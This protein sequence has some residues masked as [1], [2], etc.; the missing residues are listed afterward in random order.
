MFSNLPHLELLDLNGNMLTNFDKI[1]TYL[2]PSLPNLTRLSLYGNLFTVIV[3]GQNF[4]QYMQKNGSKIKLT[5]FYNPFE[6]GCQNLQLFQLLCSNATRIHQHIFELYYCRKQNEMHVIDEHVY[7][8]LRGQQ[9]TCNFLQ[10]LPII[11]PSAA[12]VFCILL[13]RT[14]YKKRWRF[15]L[16]LYKLRHG[17][18]NTRRTF[19]AETN[20]NNTILY[21]IYMSYHPDQCDWIEYFVQMLEQYDTHDCDKWTHI[22]S[23][24]P[25]IN[26]QD[27]DH[28]VPATAALS[29]EYDETLT[30]TRTVTSHNCKF[31][32]STAVSRSRAT[33]SS[34]TC[35]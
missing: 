23:Q 29:T 10:L 22:V 15:K 26:W 6:C 24:P 14:I 31:I 34:Q 12:T 18:L 28:V 2:F 35:I 27:E 32:K 9:Y 11:A 5:Y 8:T 3:P 13:A 20:T 30:T 25:H 21:D 1:E 4:Q 17:L 33:C 7:S 19:D 16:L